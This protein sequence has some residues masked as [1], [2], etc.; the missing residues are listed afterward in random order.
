MKNQ[1][2]SSKRLLDYNREGTLPPRSYYLPFDAKDD[3]KYLVN[4]VDRQSSSRFLSLDGEWQIK[5]YSSPDE[6]QLNVTPTEK[7]TVPSCVQLWGYDQI[8]YLNTRYPFPFDPPQVPKANPTFHYQRKFDIADISQKYYLNFEGVDSF[9]WVFINKYFV[10]IGQ[11]SHATNEFDVTNFLTFGQNVIDVVVAKWCTGSY[12]E[13]QDKFRWTGIFRSVY[14]LK[15]PKEHITDYK[16]TTDI[17]QNNGVITVENLSNVSMECTLKNEKIVVQPHQKGHFIIE[18]VQIWSNTTPYLYDLIILANGEKILERVGVRT[19][20]IENGVFKINGKHQKL[21]GVNRHE[22]NPQTGAVVSLKN[23]EEDILLMKWAGV[24]AIRTSHYPNCPQFYQL[25]DYH[26]MYVMDEADV[27]SHGVVTSQGGYD[28]E[29]WHAYANKDIFEPSVTDRELNLYE[30]DKNAT[31]VVIWSLGNES[32]YGKMFYAGADYI[33][34]KDTR[35]I[36]YEGISQQSVEFY[37][38]RVDF[39]SKMYPPVSDL[40]QYLADSK[41]TRPYVLCEYS[42]AMGNSNGDLHDYW[43]KIDS[44]DRFVGGFVWEWCDHAVQVEDKFLYGGDFG[45]KEH[46]GNFCVDG[47]VFPNRA[48]KSNLLE[49]KA[50]YQGK[51]EKKFLLPPCQLSQNIQTKGRLPIEIDGNAKIHAVGNVKLRYPFTINIFRAYI[52][53]DREVKHQWAQFVGYEQV[54]DY[55]TTDDVTTTYKGR[56]VK[57]GLSP[58]LTFTLAITPF[59][60][61]FDI[62]FSYQVANYIDYLPRIGLEFAVDKKF[63]KFEYQGYGPSESYVDKHFA[64]NFG[65]Y[66]TTA[67]QNMQNNIMPQENGS[68]FASTELQLEGLCQITSQKPFSF[69]V[70][71]YSTEQLEKATHNY[72][73]ESYAT[74]VNLDLSMSGVGSNSCGP[75]LDKKYRAQKSCS[76]TFRFVLLD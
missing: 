11:I 35:P 12:L 36:H 70:L 10:G 6:V 59:G 48:I 4:I 68:H 63:C 75:L 8:Q 57:N 26:G 61:G 34:A 60:N 76:N 72:Q 28:R 16:I 45:E 31:C 37:T 42:H 32:G 17:C 66:S 18:N 55:V 69:S 52:D 44:N 39:V 51:R 25:C 41:E 13:D 14:L 73:L 65:K 71:P 20:K 7:I 29:L 19:V 46:D 38:N 53:N 21:K 15:R 43:Q 58:I 3:I 67:T 24:N 33:H 49:L 1:V 30:R 2:I 62:Q 9:F 56:L 64:S 74:F 22:S 50:I 40:D 54:V 5:Q 47:L 27:E 23:I